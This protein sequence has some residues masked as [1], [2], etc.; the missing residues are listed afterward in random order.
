M[1]QNIVYFVALVALIL[2]SI[3]TFA[4]PPGGGETECPDK[5][6]T[7]E[8]SCC[9]TSGGSLYYGSIKH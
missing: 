5:C 1:K 9:Y 4:L 6:V 7:N 8:H 2:S 3:S